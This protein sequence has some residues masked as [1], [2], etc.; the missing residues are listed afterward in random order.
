MQGAPL[1]L[2][3]T[4]SH[5][6]CLLKLR[7]AGI[8][9]CLI[10]LSACTVGTDYTP[11]KDAFNDSWDALNEDAQEGIDTSDI[12][13]SKDS[14][15]PTSLWWEQFG[16]EILSGLIEKAL[17]GN[18]DLKIAQARIDEARAN[19]QYSSAQLYPEIDAQA[20]VTRSSLSAIESSEPD[21][22]KQAGVNGNWDIDP[23]G[24]NLRQREAAKYSVEAAQQ[25]FAQARLNLIADVVRNYS[26]LRAAQ[27]QRELTLH[28][29]NTPRDTLRITHALRKAQDVTDL[30][31]SRVEAQIGVTQSR[32]PQ[33]RTDIY[34]A[35]N[36]LCVLT[37]Q[38]PGTLRKLLM[39]KKPMLSMP[40]SLVVLSPIATI[41]QRP[42]VHAAERRL[43]QASALSN[44]AFSQ[45]FP[46][47]SLSAFYG[48][49]RSDVFGALSPW[50]AMVQGLFPL[51]DFGRIRA[52][53]H[54]ADARQ[55][56]AFHTYE[57]TVLAA[58]EDTENSLNAYMD[59]R[60][61]TALLHKVAAEQ[62]RAVTIASKQYKGGIVT[63]LD[64]LDAQRNQLDAQS[65]WVLSQQMA[66]DNLIQLYHSLGQGPATAP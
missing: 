11:P 12:E 25:D 31:V 50:N 10:C 60:K 59:E 63:Q 56:Q 2:S 18:H 30:D 7:H 27:A 38:Q 62:A 9:G 42:D 37:G 43:A 65:N 5:S 54:G 51:I 46:H 35:I 36:R 22:I 53:M 6:L 19:E 47:L 39:P 33:I 49:Q 4:F 16:D 29:L 58:L 40:A 24:A 34:T 23:F 57:Q 45:L 55:E 3:D 21:T 13:I 61:R 1:I 52:Q 20:S 8:L 15:L 26:H 48:E 44:A 32:L 28:N 66:T 41:A 17:V 14:A 64:L